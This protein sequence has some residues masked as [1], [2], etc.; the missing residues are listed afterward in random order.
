MLRGSLPCQI[1][2]PK[3]KY[4][5]KLLALA[6]GSPNFK[7]RNIPVLRMEYF[8]IGVQVDLRHEVQYFLSVVDLILIGD[9]QMLRLLLYWVFL[10]FGSEDAGVR[11]F[12]FDE[13]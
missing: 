1:H 6:Q 8:V 10:L 13:G 3:S 7:H 5:N 12:V 2:M 9:G 11:L 4:H